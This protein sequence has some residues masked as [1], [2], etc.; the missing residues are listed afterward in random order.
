MLIARGDEVIGIFAETMREVAMLKGMEMGEITVSSGIYPA[1]ISVASAIGALIT[2]HPRLLVQLD[3]KRWPEVYEDVAQGR[4]DIGVADATEAVHRPDLAIEPIRESRLFFFCRS[5]HPLLRRPSLSLEDILEHPWAGP[6]IPAPMRLHIPLLERGF[7]AVDAET[8]LLRPRVLTHT[9]PAAKEVV[10]AGDAI[11]AAL[12]SQ[13]S[14]ELA[15]G[16]CA[17]IPLDLPWLKVSYGFIT[18]RGRSLSPAGTAFKELLLAV[19]NRAD[20]LA[21]AAARHG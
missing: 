9:F 7:G 10:L 6:Q 14:R 3:V 2:Q 11:S 21:E 4:A 5:G 15:D 12:P 8:N 13:I 17:L 18:K 19:E 1:D 16:S 20:R